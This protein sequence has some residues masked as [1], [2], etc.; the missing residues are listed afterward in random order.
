[1]SP[2]RGN[3]AMISAVAMHPDLDIVGAEDLQAPAQT[4]PH[5]TAGH[6]RKLLAEFFPAPR[7]KLIRLL[8]KNCRRF[9]SFFLGGSPREVISEF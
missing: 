6:D 7:E 3:W 9:S 8:I 1:M 5:V 2:G 4:Q